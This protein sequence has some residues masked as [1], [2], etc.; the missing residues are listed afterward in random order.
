VPVFCPYEPGKGK[1]EFS[2]DLIGF[3][4]RD[5]AQTLQGRKDRVQECEWDI[6]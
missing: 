4:L 3:Y 6:G 2:A 5:F 1:D